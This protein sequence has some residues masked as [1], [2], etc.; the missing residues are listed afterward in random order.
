M[1]FSEHWSVP[2]IKQ[3]LTS[4]LSIDFSNHVIEVTKCKEESLMYANQYL[5]RYGVPE[6]SCVDDRSKLD[7]IYNSKQLFGDTYDVCPT[8]NKEMVSHRAEGY[9][10]VPGAFK[11]RQ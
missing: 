4:G 11:Q 8:N 3:H 7:N 10:Y 1:V 9:Y 2:Q 5:Y 6:M